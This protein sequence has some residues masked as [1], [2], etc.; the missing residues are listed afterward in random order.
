MGF[1]ELRRLLA[2][3]DL[4]GFWNAFFDLTEANGFHDLGHPWQDGD[5]SAA[6]SAAIAAALGR[7][8]PVALMS[9]THIQ[10][11]AE[12]VHAMAV[13]DARL[14]AAV[15]FPELGLGS[16]AVLRSG[17]GA[18]YYEFFIGARQHQLAAAAC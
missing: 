12:L 15:Y 9:V 10:A 4:D 2:R 1:Q 8:G 11:D 17:G 3:Q 6:I 5:G 18:D 14:M 13:V 7:T 16:L